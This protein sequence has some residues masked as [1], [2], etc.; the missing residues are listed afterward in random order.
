M[1]QFLFKN[2]M[3]PTIRKGFHSSN[4]DEIVGYPGVSLLLTTTVNAFSQASKPDH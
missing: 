1:V 3:I 4:E 2:P